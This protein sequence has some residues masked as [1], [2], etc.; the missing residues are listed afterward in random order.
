MA[1]AVSYKINTRTFPTHEAQT[2]ALGRVKKKKEF[3]AMKNMKKMIDRKY[4][5][6]EEVED[7]DPAWAMIENGQMTEEQLYSNLYKLE[8][9]NNP[10]G[11]WVYAYDQYFLDT[12]RY[13]G[14][15]ECVLLDPWMRPVWAQ[16]L[17]T[18]IV[19]NGLDTSGQFAG[20]AHAD[21]TQV[22]DKANLRALSSNDVKTLYY[23]GYKFNRV[24]PQTETT[25]V[26]RSKPIDN[27]GD[28]LIFV[29]KFF[30]GIAANAQK[31]YGS[32]MATDAPTLVCMAFDQSVKINECGSQMLIDWCGTHLGMTDQK[33]RLS[34]KGLNSL[35][36]FIMP[37][38]NAHENDEDE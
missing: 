36:G 20:Y 2:Q 17:E 35:F 16:E 25:W 33:F 18:T 13:F 29:G 26:G 5:G 12:L 6:Y 21:G 38:M 7:K 3:L 22:D 24:G 30:P 23:G 8:R 32:Q 4:L 10:L 27:V 37:K 14:I 1:Q 28:R 34:N 11:G 19:P 15:F 9:K 31:Q